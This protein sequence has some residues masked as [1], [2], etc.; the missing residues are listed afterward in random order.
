MFKV[1]NVRVWKSL[2]WYADTRKVQFLAAVQA[3]HPSHG[4]KIK[5]SAT[6]LPD[7]LRSWIGMP[8]VTESCFEPV[9][10]EDYPGQRSHNESPTSANTC[11]NMPEDKSARTTLPKLECLSVLLST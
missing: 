10:E 5:A 9:R 2:T 6:T 7:Q 3:L 1:E 8:D 4:L 11:N